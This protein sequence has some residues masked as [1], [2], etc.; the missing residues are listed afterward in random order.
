MKFSIYIKGRGWTF[1][2]A[3]ALS[4]TDN[5]DF[6]VTSYPKF[7]V[8]KYNV[9]ANK[10]KSIFFIEIL[11]RLLNKF[12]PLFYK[13]KLNFDANVIVDWVTDTIYSSFFIQNSDL[14][15]LGFGNTT[16]KIIKKAKKK[17]IKT[18]YFLNNSSPSYRKVVKEEYDKLGLSKFYNGEP[19]A[20][21]RKINESINMADYIGALSSFQKQT[22]IDEGVDESKIFL[23]FLGVDTSVFFPKKIKKDKFIVIYI[24]NDFVRKG[25]KYLIDAFNSLKLDNS[26]LWI[27]G[28][29]T[30]NLAERIVK[31][32]KNN[33]F[34]DSVSEFKLPDLYNQ[35]SIFCLPTLEEGMPAVILQAM[36][37][38]LPVIT[39]P[40][41]KDVITADGQEG[42]IVEPGNTSLIS[43]KIKF[44][45]D[46]PNKIIEMGAKARN[47]IE[48]KFTFDCVAKR[49]INFC[50]T[51]L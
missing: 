51:K 11:V 23:S 1:Q 20:L 34:I 44:F 2:L 22:Y 17:N 4:K 9:P 30:R 42:F 10:I 45:Y 41:C 40:Y 50:N 15:L 25:A 36:A 49:I 24:G 43:E 12:D 39:T 26:E 27:V 7:F 48:N 21:T 33:I 31:I 29:N 13:L 47:R 14:L 5:L 18:I 46:N 19:K 28:I 3:K 32:E 6:L 16:C 37:C 35:A 38:A 8:K